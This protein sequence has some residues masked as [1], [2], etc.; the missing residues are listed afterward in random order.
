MNN[1]NMNNVTRLFLK[2]LP[3]QLFLSLTSGLTNFVNGLIV[4]NFFESNAM[5]TIGLI[6]PMTSFLGGLA[7]IISGGSLILCGRYMGKGEIKKINAVF[8]NGIITLISVGILLSVGAFIFAPTLAISFGAKGDLIANTIAYIRGLS[9]GILPLLMIPSFMAFLQINNKS[10][11]SLLSSIILGIINTILGLLNVFVFKGGITGVGLAS[12]IS[13]ILIVLMIIA[14][15]FFNKGMVN[16]DIKLFDLQ[17][18]K[19][20]LIFGSP[21]ALANILYA[22]RNVFI[23]RYAFAVGGENAVS[24]LAILGSCGIFYDSINI[25]VGNSI[26]ILASVFI[27]EKNVDSLKRLMKT[28]LMIGFMLAGFKI[29]VSHLF[30][31]RLAMVFGAVDDI[32][33]ITKQLFCYYAWSSPFNMITLLFI[34]ILQSQ[35][36]VVFCNF[37]YIFNCILVPLFSCTILANIFGIRAIWFLYTLAE[38][39]TLLII[40]IKANINK[41]GFVN[42][43][44]ELFMLGKDLNNDNK[45]S[46]TIQ[47]LDKVATISEQIQNFC[48][49]H[50]IDHKRAMYSALCMEEMAGNVIEHGFTKDN[51]QHS[52][53]IFACVEDEDVTLRLRDNCKPFDPKTKLKM[54][55]NDDVTKNIGIK[56]VSKIAK[57]MNYQTT[58]GMNVLTI[59]L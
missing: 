29:I 13:N 22:L 31:D 47:D 57:E 58:F 45:I 12:S 21:A 35:G 6:A 23:N 37:V 25:G 41:K 50:G 49:E 4:G 28:S 39:V 59:K 51:K 20:I 46:I 11:I 17:I 40:Y 54:V 52:L 34:G 24:A 16:F 9:L 19:K 56:M 3:V 15:F 38:W 8:V 14:Y 7:A 36:K 43:T 55:D 53:D 10:N 44:E 42:K 5:R 33:P 1:N 18:V 27:G 32:I 2:L 30:G 26:S 48:D